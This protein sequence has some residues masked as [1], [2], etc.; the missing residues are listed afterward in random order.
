MDGNHHRLRKKTTVQSCFSIDVNYLTRKG[1][2]KPGVERMGKLAWFWGA[3]PTD[4][5]FNL[6]YA[7]NTA[8]DEPH[9]RLIYRLV[10]TDQL[11]V[12]SVRL[13]RTR[14]RL[15]GVRWWFLCPRVFN[16][17]ACSRRVGKIYLPPGGDYFGCRHCY[18]LTY[19]SVQQHDKRV[20]ALVRNTKLMARL[21]K[22]LEN[23]SSSKH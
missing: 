9:V 17:Q 20:D 23:A 13:T 15:G 4:I 14:Q 8:S 2:L 12:Y 22:N 1:I 16:G 18:N 19:T 7:V 21:M 11:M 6:A 10:K 3:N 5:R